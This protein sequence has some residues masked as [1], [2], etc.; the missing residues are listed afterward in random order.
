MNYIESSQKEQ[1]D[2]GWKRKFSTVLQYSTLQIESARNIPSSFF[3]ELLC[4]R[5]LAKISEREEWTTLLVR[6][7]L[8]RMPWG[9]DRLAM[10]QILWPGFPPT[11]LTF[12]K[13]IGANL[14][15]GKEPKNSWD[16]S[17]GNVSHTPWAARHLA[18]WPPFL[19]CFP[20]LDASLKGIGSLIEWWALLDCTLL[21]D[22]QF[23]HHLVP[24]SRDREDE[25]LPGMC[26]SKDGN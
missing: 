13:W 1:F 8:Y 7:N 26:L 12:F 20:H 9:M 19:L 24:F 18:V 22:N 6:S 21:V 16:N 15:G 11:K 5:D 14:Q 17:T 23:V 2:S 10:G 25:N 4:A 3:H